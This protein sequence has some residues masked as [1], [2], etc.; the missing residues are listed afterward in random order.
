MIKYIIAF[1]LLTVIMNFIYVFLQRRK[2]AK[3]VPTYF[4]QTSPILP[5]ISSLIPICHILFLFGQ[6]ELYEMEIKEYK[7]LFDFMAKELK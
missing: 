6:I 1:Y 2:M 3:Y 5:M 4:A 7:D